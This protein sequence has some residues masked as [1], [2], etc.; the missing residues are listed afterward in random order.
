MVRSATLTLKYANSGKREQVFEILDEYKR[1]AQFFVD[2]LW[3]KYA[4]GE[5][6]GAKAAV[7]AEKLLV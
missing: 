7:G 3:E 4:V 5:G 6:H 1:V 2:F